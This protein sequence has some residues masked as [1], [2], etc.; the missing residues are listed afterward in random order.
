M[1]NISNFQKIADQIESKLI[2]QDNIRE[3]LLRLSREVIRLSGQSIENFHRSKNKKSK[4]KLVQAESKLKKIKEYIDREFQY[5]QISIINVAMQEYTEARLFYE[6]I[7]NQK[8][9]TVEE[10]DIP[11]QAYLLGI[12]DL[13]GEIRRYILE[14]LVEGN[15]EEAK[16][17]YES[18][19]ELYGTILQ[20][21]Y[22]K[23]LISDFR[24]KKDT[25][26]VLVERT[27]SDLFVATQSRKYRQNLNEKKE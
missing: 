13:I 14:R 27:L 24:R 25:A 10:L 23:N 3:E 9:L 18:M 15:L 6:L 21:E 8:L 1:V 16:K 12:A 2:Q 19:K 11:E 22:G 20:V 26:R 4:E 7:N 17:L 5:N